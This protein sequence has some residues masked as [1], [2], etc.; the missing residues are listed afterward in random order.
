MRYQCPCC[1]Y[2]TYTAPPTE[3]YGFICPV[4]FW[5]SDKRVK[6]IDD[7]SELN[8]DTTLS[9]ARKYYQSVGACHPRM[10]KY[11][12]APKEEELSL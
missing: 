1:D 11:V 9:E 7:V 6:S 4:C 8:H 2:Y 10:I 3:D 12:R 5:E